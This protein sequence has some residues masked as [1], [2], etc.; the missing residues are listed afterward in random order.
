[1]V[2]PGLL[3]LNLVPGMSNAD[4]A[5]EF[6]FK[7][8]ALQIKVCLMWQ[9]ESF[10]LFPHCAGR[11]SSKQLNETLHFLS[12]VMEFCGFDNVNTQP[13]KQKV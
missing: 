10:M 1:M 12:K 7:Q 13:V 8:L 5:I 2:S 3:S 9:A 11:C 6:T 4:A